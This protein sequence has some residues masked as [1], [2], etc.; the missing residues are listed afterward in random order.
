M[1]WK[2]YAPFLLKYGVYLACF[3][4]LL[5]WTWLAIEKYRSQPTATFLSVTAGDDNV[6]ISLPHLIFC[7]GEN[8]SFISKLHKSLQADPNFDVDGYVGNASK[9]VENL[10]FVQVSFPFSDKLEIKKNLSDLLYPTFNWYF[11]PCMGFNPEGLYINV[12][13]VDPFISDLIIKLMTP[14][15]DVQVSYHSKFDSPNAFETYPFHLLNRGAIN[16]HG[17]FSSSFTLV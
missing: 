1:R 16:K 14:E 12:N 7:L 8:W 6:K 3:G 2:S 10:T 5:F 15:K 13:D 17:K 11:G 9:M 4:T